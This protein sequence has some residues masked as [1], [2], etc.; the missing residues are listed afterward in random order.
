MTLLY[1][2]VLLGFPLY[3][4]CER[5]CTSQ[6]QKIYFPNLPMLENA[7]RR[8]RDLSR[9]L[10]Y[11]ILLLLFLALSA[12]VKEQPVTEQHGVGYDIALLLDASD[13]MR[14]AERFETA[15]AIISDFID[16]RKG[17]RLALSLFADYAY[18]SVPLTYHK[19]ALKT[20]LRHLRIGVAGRRQ[21]ALYE[22]LYLG[23]GLF[24]ES[25]AREKIVILLTDGLNTVKSIPLEAALAKAKKEQLK[26][27]TIGIG[28]D[29][30][31]EILQRIASETRGKFYAATNP[32]ALQSIYD[33]INRLEKS[34]FSTETT[35]YNI[36]LFRYPLFLALLLIL[37]FLWF[38][39]RQQR[40]T[41][42]H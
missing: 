26:V 30:R 12:P 18:L 23:A 17:D 5:R 25:A 15:K 16:S 31:K 21:T 33:D 11:A 24:T 37:P 10:R 28:D 40:L 9:L 36:P 4:L 6:I 1:P 20:V 39:Y 2:W 35:S 13:S 3:L 19:E 29:Y 41:P 8:G 32:K 38:E 27:Y 14:E 22:A 7:A 42:V 34:R